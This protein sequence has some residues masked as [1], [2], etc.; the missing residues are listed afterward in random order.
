MKKKRSKRAKTKA[1]PLV[2]VVGESGRITYSSPE[3]ASLF[4]PLEAVLKDTVAA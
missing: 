3:V 4:A 2:M 1:T